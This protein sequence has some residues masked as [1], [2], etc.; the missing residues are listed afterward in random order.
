MGITA[1]APSLLLLQPL[2]FCRKH[3]FNNASISTAARSGSFSAS[4]AEISAMPAAPRWMTVR[5][6]SFLI[7]PGR[8]P[9]YPPLR[10]LPPDVQSPGVLHISLRGSKEDG[11]EG[12]K[13]APAFRALTDFSSCGMRPDEHLSRAHPLPGPPECSPLPVDTVRFHRHGDIEAIIVNK[14]GA[15]ASG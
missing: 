2:S 5:T 6:L 9:G 11:A 10:K 7:P 4:I 14:A 15:I 1:D 8:I 13:S 3:S 12:E